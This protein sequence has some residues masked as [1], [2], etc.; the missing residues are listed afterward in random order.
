MPITIDRADVMKGMS[1]AREKKLVAM[2]ED[3]ISAAEEYKGQR[4]SLHRR[5][6]DMYR[7]KPAVD[8]QSWPWRNAA[9]YFIPVAAVACDIMKSIAF[10]AMFNTDP[11][12]HGEGV[13]DEETARALSKYFFRHVWR[14]QLNLTYLSDSWNLDT[15]VDGTGVVK[16]Y[17]DSSLVTVRNMAEPDITPVMSKQE[18][19]YLGETIIQETPTGEMNVKITEDVNAIPANQP[20]VETVDLSFLYPAPGSNADL[21]YPEC[22]WYYEAMW[23]TWPEIQAKKRFGWKNIDDKLQ[24]QLRERE[25]TEKE[26][27]ERQ[28]SGVSEKELEKIRVLCFYMRMVL[29]GEIMMDDGTTERQTFMK[30][31]GIEEEVILYYFPDTEK[32]A[33]ISPLTRERP[34]NQRPHIVNYYD[35]IDKY[36]YGQGMMDKLRHLQKL[37]NTSFNQMVD[38]GSLQNLPFFFYSPSVTGVIPDMS[39]IRPGEGIPVNDAKGIQMARFA[40]NDQHF[41]GLMMNAQQWVERVSSVT[42]FNAGRQSSGPNAPRTARQTMQLLQQSNNL[43]AYRIAMWAEAYKKMFRQ[44]F[45]MM[46]ANGTGKVDFKYLNKDTGLFQRAS[47][48]M[49]AFQGDVDFTFQLNPDKAMQQQKVQNFFGLMSQVPWMMNN[50]QSMRALLREVSISFDMGEKFDQMWPEEQIP[51]QQQQAQMQQQQQ[52]A[53]GGGPPPPGRPPGEFSAAPQP[54]GFKAQQPQG[55]G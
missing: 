31:G 41:Q 33:Y 30:E 7:C 13:E 10:Q 42:D 50:P 47:I 6:W 23:F 25:M 19:E 24:S 15:L 14:K 43:S 26:A 17:H 53:Q 52:M 45:K 1:G 40:G 18:V 34:D 28:L 36:F 35:R 37:V 49:T 22:P 12:V 11:E 21:Q 55:A 54:G 9:N 29:P 51:Q 8:V 16:T 46:Q 2:L 39:A 4:Q 5:N 32:I 48:P 38:F 3:M 44:T 27:D 20:R